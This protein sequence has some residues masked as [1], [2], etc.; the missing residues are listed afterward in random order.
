MQISFSWKITAIS[1]RALCVCFADMLSSSS[2]RLGT[3]RS[4]IRCTST[5]Q[6]FPFRETNEDAEDNQ[7]K[8]K[9][10]MC[11][12]FRG[13]LLCWSG[14]GILRKVKDKPAWLRFEIMQCLGFDAAK[15]LYAIL[16][17]FHA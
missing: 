15:L 16:F 5:M 6:T 3:A 1:N 9:Q 4:R 2:A 12:V 13:S 7:Q 8:L 10:K 11:V 14:M 17:S